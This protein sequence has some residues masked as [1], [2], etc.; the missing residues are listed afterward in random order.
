LPAPQFEYERRHSDL[1]MEDNGMDVETVRNDPDGRGSSR[2]LRCFAKRRG[3]CTGGCS[4]EARKDL[5]RPAKVEHYFNS[6]K[7]M[8]PNDSFKEMMTL[9]QHDAHTF[10]WHHPRRYGRKE[11]EE[12]TQAG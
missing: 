10:Q 9:L 12:E 11:K 2:A 8:L 7:T 6:G 5:P 4:R 1:D 3:S